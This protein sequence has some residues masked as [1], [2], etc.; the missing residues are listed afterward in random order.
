MAW[1]PGRGWRGHQKL[2]QR[3][4]VVW[5]RSFAL[6]EIMDVVAAFSLS[7]RS[8]F[9]RILQGSNRVVRVTLAPNSTHWP[10]YIEVAWVRIEG[11]GFFF[12]ASPYWWICSGT[13]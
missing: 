1:P 8:V 7:N 9:V 10:S 2:G 12:W 3:T 6:S 13:I 4:G 5:W 11:F